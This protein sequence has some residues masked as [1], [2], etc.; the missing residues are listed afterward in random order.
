M[1]YIA[2]PLPW[3]IMISELDIPTKKF[4]FSFTYL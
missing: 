2:Q 1:Q 3:I 4:G